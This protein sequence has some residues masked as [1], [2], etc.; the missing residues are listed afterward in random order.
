[1][2]IICTYDLTDLV[3]VIAS[4]RP[5]SRVS[6]TDHTESETRW[7][8][9]TDVQTPQGGAPQ[10]VSLHAKSDLTRTIVNNKQ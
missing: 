6:T 8:G 5:V 9:G 3:T 7:R 4:V 1:M 2:L 10:R